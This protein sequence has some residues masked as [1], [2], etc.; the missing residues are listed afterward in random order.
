MERGSGQRTVRRHY[1]PT[2]RRYHEGRG[3]YFRRNLP[4]GDR[5]WNYSPR[6]VTY[7]SSYHGSESKPW[8]NRWAATSPGRFR[9]CEKWDSNRKE[10]S[11]LRYHGPNLDG[12]GRVSALIESKAFN[13]SSSAGFLHISESKRVSGFCRIRMVKDVLETSRIGCG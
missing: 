11:N 9:N 10:A 8:S 13:F 2:V 12:Q 4:D 7:F 1:A 6:R 3:S 5:R